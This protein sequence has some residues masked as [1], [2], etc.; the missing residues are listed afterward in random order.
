M[1]AG[2][3]DLAPEQASDER[4]KQRRKRDPKIDV[5]HRLTLEH[6]EVGDV[7]GTPVTEQHDQDSEADG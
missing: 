5:L 2:T 7:D 3:P 6:I 4:A 1:G